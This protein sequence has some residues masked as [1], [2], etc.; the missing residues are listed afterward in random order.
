VSADG[1]PVPPIRPDGL[2]LTEHR[3][4]QEKFWTVERFAWAA[5]LIV[6][7]LAALGLT[8]DSGVFGRAT[9]T[10]P[11]ATLDYPSIAR[12][13][14]PDQFNLHFDA[15]DPQRTVLLSPQF[16]ASF[17]IEQIQPEPD[18]SQARADGTLMVFRVLD[19]GP[20]DITWLMRAKSP[21]LGTYEI[22]VDGGAA[23]SLGILTLP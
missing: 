9:A 17:L 23:A 6:V 14:A 8:G 22:A 12:W 11:G 10:L 5:F 1:P 2:Q 3:S 13:E 7:I 15:G 20:T 16:A 19:G 4:F 21:G 18:S